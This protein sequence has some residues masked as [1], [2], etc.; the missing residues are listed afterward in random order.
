MLSV[1]MGM[2]FLSPVAFAQT[3]E[4]VKAEKPG[5]SQ[6]A[7]NERQDRINEKQDK[8]NKEQAKV[9]KEQEN[10]SHIT[11]AE[12]RSAVATFVQALLSA[13]DREKGGI[14]EQVR[15]VA[16]EQNE[17]KDEVANEIEEIQNR[18]GL[19]TFFFGTDY[20]N[21]GAVRSTM[22][23]TASQIEELKTLLEELTVDESKTELEEEIAKLEEE[24]KKVED[25][26]KANESKFS[27]FGGIVKLFYN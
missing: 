3:G 14:G 7:I 23:K 13:A 9:N 2:V 6:E 27:L 1:I 24:Q 16:Q 22:A 26:L 18:S 10:K 17:D 19:K 20:K 11:G 8:I 21:I 25:F 4:D 5:Q 12:H 15:A